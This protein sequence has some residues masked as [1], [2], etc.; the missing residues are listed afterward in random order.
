MP[1]LFSGTGK[2]PLIHIDHKIKQFFY[3]QILQKQYGTLQNPDTY[4]TLHY[5]AEFQSS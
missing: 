4:G 2:Y 1:G 3:F 5:S